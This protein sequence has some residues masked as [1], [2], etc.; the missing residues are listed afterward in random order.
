MSSAQNTLPSVLVA[1]AT[2]HGATQEIAEAVKE[3]LVERGLQAIA[4]PV[5]D[6]T[7]IAGYDAIII[8]SAVYMGR[9]MKG[10]RAFVDE[11]R[12]ELGAKD[13]WLFSSGPVGPTEESAEPFGIDETMAATGAH[14]HQVFAGRVD[15]HNL[16]LA[17][18]A[19]LRMVKATD[20]DY[21]DWEA[22][23]RW[24]N[25]IADALAGPGSHPA[26]AQEY[27]PSAASS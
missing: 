27:Q 4:M 8:G 19:V 15:E 12:R 10:A 24:G 3:T 17:E 1:Y 11:H 25:A 2:R 6:V 9:W 14:A 22:I 16:G 7:G 13:V 20:G 23:R 5:Q 18:R 21:R 26:V